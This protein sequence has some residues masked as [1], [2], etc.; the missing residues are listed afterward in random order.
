VVGIAKNAAEISSN[1]VAQQA[2]RF[3]IASSLIL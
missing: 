2:I 3:F 1:P